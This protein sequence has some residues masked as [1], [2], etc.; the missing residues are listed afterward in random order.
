MDRNILTVNNANDF[1]S[2]Q[3]EIKEFYSSEQVKSITTDDKTILGIINTEILPEIKLDSYYEEPD[4]ESLS[5]AHREKLY[6]RK[7]TDSLDKSKVL[8]IDFSV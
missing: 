1:D 7:S 6:G 3:K 2:I 5:N 8:N 4:W